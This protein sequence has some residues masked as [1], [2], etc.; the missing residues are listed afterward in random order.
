MR[1]NVLV[2]DLGGVYRTAYHETYTAHFVA[3]VAKVLIK[4]R[5]GPLGRCPHDLAKAFFHVLRFRPARFHHGMVRLTGLGD[6]RVAE[7][8]DAPLDDTGFSRLAGE[9]KGRGPT[10]LHPESKRR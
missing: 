4:L 2:L 3:D 7:L 10:G 1:A 6:V 9:E 8:N 5:N